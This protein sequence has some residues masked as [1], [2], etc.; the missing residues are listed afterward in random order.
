MYSPRPII[1]Q[2]EQFARRITGESFAGVLKV[3]YGLMGIH[4][5]NANRCALMECA[6]TTAPG[7]PLL[8]DATLTDGRI[9]RNHDVPDLPGRRLFVGARGASY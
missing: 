4:S 7:L 5:K 8:R 3:T 9:C 1:R 6:A 2:N